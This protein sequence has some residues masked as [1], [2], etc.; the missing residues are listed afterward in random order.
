M[1]SRTII[2]LA[3]ALFA[4]M[5]TIASPLS[6]EQAGLLSPFSVLRRQDCECAVCDVG[7]GD[8][9]GGDLDDYN[10]CV[11]VTQG[12]CGRSCGDLE[13]NTGAQDGCYLAD[14]TRNKPCENECVQRQLRAKY[15]ESN[16][17]WEYC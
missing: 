17:D 1:Q 16:P 8:C 2:Q 15:C 10:A 14:I 4:A 3:L 6:A 5:P 13:P 12:T 9:S 7:P 11:A